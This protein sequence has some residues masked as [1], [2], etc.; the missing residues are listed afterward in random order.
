MPI[1]NLNKKRNTSGSY[2]RIIGNEKI[3]NLVTSIHSTA[4]RSGN[5]VAERLKLSYIGD[6]PIYDSENVNTPTKTL[7]I[8]EKNKNGV[9]I[10]NGYINIKNNNG[11]N[12]KQE[13]DLIIFINN[14]LYCFEIKEG[15]N[16]DTKKSK[17]E[18]DLVENFVSYFTKLNFNVISGLLLINMKNNQHSIKDSRAKSYIMSGE[19][20]TKKFNFDFKMY[21]DIQKNEQPINE[22]IVIEEMRK[23]LDDYDKKIK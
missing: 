19:E 22:K 7:K 2:S 13:V 3:S 8:L 21:K 1:I 15:E 14:I 9:I 10:F 17:A 12:K 23:I 6:L 18:L 5:E 16:L 20:F 4:I 11:K